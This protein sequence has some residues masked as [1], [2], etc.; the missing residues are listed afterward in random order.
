MA[1]HYWRM[2]VS[3]EKL[4][5]G[6]QHFITHSFKQNQQ[7]Y[8]KLAQ[9][10]QSPEVMM[11]SCADSRVDPLAITQAEPGQIFAIRNVANLVPKYE[12]D[13]SQ[14]CLSTEA[15][16]KYGVLHLQ[17]KHII[18]MGHSHCGGIKALI[19][20]DQQEQHCEAIHEWVGQMD[21][22]KKELIANHPNATPNK[23]SELCER[24]SMLYSQQNLLTYPY[25][26]NAITQHKL[27]IHLWHFDIESGHISVY[28]PTTRSYNP[29]D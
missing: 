25:V 27:A 4:I 5:T 22:A 7:Q 24:H 17:V 14:Q 28:N 2:T 26:Q 18:I 16:L 20:M 13:R 15:A 23:I 29:L 12:L 1:K 9:Q 3:Y 21:H 8:K 19:D 10:G 11:I 6:Y